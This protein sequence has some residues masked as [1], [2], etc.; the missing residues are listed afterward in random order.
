MHVIAQQLPGELIVSDITAKV[1]GEKKPVRLNL[2][3]SVL[4]SHST[5]RK[6]RL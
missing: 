2:W 5:L 6:R 4:C 3:H 1:R